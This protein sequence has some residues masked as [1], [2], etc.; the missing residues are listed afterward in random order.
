[1][2]CFMVN[3]MDE[4]DLYLFRRQERSLTHQYIIQ[5]ADTVGMKTGKALQ[6]GRT[7]TGL[8]RVEP[9]VC[10]PVASAPSSET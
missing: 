6:Y 4:Q 9:L 8:G 2:T 3:R 5:L 1:M 10:L 7:W